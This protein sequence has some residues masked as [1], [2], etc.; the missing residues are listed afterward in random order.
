LPARAVQSMAFSPL[1]MD[2]CRH[3]VEA[4]WH[5]PRNR[6]RTSIE[7]PR[8]RCVSWPQGSITPGGSHAVRILL[9]PWTASRTCLAAVPDGKPVPTFPELLYRAAW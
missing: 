2:L 8:R 9:K 6:F 7:I 4:T 5:G 3:S 1:D